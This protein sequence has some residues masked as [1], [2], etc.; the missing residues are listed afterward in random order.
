MQSILE[1]LKKIIVKM[2]FFGYLFENVILLIF[3]MYAD[4]FTAFFYFFYILM[5]YSSWKFHKIN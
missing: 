4:K 5:A 2:F 3:Y 1:C